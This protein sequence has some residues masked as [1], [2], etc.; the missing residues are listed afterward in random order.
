MHFPI[1]S[2][3]LVFHI[4]FFLDHFSKILILLNSLYIP[5]E[6]DFISDNEIYPEYRIENVFKH[7]V[8]Y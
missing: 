7:E 4:L 1:S 5:N 8:E 6:T 2:P 3:E